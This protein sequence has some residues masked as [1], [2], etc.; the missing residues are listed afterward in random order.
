MM[1][2][3]RS[4]LT[5][6]LGLA[7]LATV[8]AACSVPTTASS[9]PE[10]ST[11]SLPPYLPGWE[12]YEVLDDASFDL[13]TGELTPFSLAQSLL[14]EP[15]TL[16][17]FRVSQVRVEALDEGGMAVLATQVGL[18]DDSVA[19]IEQRIDLVLTETGWA[20]DQAGQR[21]GCARPEFTWAEPG[22]LCP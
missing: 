18:C 15:E 10:A 3:F 12:V 19:A 14:T 5:G 11:A 8:A 22:T 20:L 6:W 21:F 7:A 13:P 9:S 16:E 17:C 2:V 1:T 4:R